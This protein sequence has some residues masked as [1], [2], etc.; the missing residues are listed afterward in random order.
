M[1]L[2]LMPEIHGDL[3]VV[4]RFSQPQSLCGFALAGDSG[5]EGS[6]SAGLLLARLMGEVCHRVQER[7]C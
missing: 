5:G 1:V 3:C 7:R 4:D 2:T 6:S